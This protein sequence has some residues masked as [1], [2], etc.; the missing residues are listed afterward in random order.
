MPINVLNDRE[1][2]V[3][4]TIKVA[5]EDYASVSLTVKI[6]SDQKYKEK[7][8]RRIGI[9][10]ILERIWFEHRSVGFQSFCWWRWEV[11]GCNRAEEP[12]Q[13]KNGKEV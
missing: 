9:I 1:Y 2:W 11:L 8:L 6:V 4:A 12:K 3:S 10:E 13:P 5:I 7:V